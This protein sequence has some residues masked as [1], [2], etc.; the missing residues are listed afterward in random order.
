MWNLLASGVGALAGAASG[1]YGSYLEYK[2]LKETNAQNLQIAREQM[3]FQERMSDTAYQRAMADM[4]KAGLNPMLAYSQGGASTPSGASAT[5]QN[6]KSALARGLD[7]VVGNAMDV[8]RL[9]NETSGTEAKAALDNESV[10][11][12]KTTQELNDSSARANLERAQRERAEKDLAEKKKE[13]LDKQMPAIEEKAK[14]DAEKNRYEKD[15]IKYDSWSDR[16]ER[17]LDTV[18][19][20]V[21]FTSSAK[22]YQRQT[23][24]Y[25][26]TF[27]NPD[28]EISGYRQRRHLPQGLKIK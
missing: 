27:I 22:G 12:Q 7:K 11:T 2:G 19:S 5:M 6:P 3:G 21:P 9:R 10:K 15:F 16:V 17:A 28:G 26:D 20:F 13:M 8:A 1:A 18:R 25:D 4:Q 23:R 24:D 14:Y